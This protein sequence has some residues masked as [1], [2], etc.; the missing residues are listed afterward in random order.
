MRSGKASKKKEEN[1]KMQH[2]KW[3]RSGDIVT[4][5]LPHPRCS[6]VAVKRHEGINDVRK[7]QNKTPL[8]KRF[9]I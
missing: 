1:K 2:M 8:A 6:D 3:T 7:V 9:R 4:F 5:D